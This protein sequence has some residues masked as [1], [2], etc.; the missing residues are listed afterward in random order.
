L[1]KLG[2]MTKSRSVISTTVL[3]SFASGSLSTRCTMARS[4][5]GITRR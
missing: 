2:L 4:R 3:A 5:L 1:T